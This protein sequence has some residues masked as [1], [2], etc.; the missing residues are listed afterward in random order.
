MSE[1][2]ARIAQLEAQGAGN[3]DGWDNVNNMADTNKVNTIQASEMT[4]ATELLSNVY[5]DRAGVQHVVDAEG[6]PT[7]QT[8]DEANTHKTQEEKATKQARSIDEVSYVDMTSVQNQEILDNTATEAYMS[9]DG[10]AM[11]SAINDTIT[12]QF[13]AQMDQYKSTPQGVW[14]DIR[15][16]A[17]ANRTNGQRSAFNDTMASGTGVERQQ[18]I[19]TLLN[20]FNQYYFN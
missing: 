15:A 1:A 5:T 12:T 16:Y 18:A 13:A 19:N 3:T 9:G 7:G 17:K 11:Q 10:D 6:N 4:Q 20:D 2:N 8:V 14:K